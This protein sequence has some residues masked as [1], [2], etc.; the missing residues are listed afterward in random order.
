[1]IAQPLGATASLVT[2]T[3]ALRLACLGHSLER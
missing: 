3:I 2:G 1:M